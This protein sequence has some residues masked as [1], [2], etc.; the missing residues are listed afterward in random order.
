MKKNIFLFT[1][2]WL[3]LLPSLHAQKASARLNTRVGPETKGGRRDIPI[4]AGKDASNY[5]IVH[6]A[7]GTMTADRLGKSDLSLSGTGKIKRKRFNT[8]QTTFFASHIFGD[9]LYLFYVCTDRYDNKIVLLAREFDGDAMKS[10][11]EYVEVASVPYYNLRDVAF[12]QLFDIRISEDGKRMLIVSQLVVSNVKRLIKRTQGK[13]HFQMSV[14]DETFTQIW[15]D[16]PKLPFKKEKFAIDGFRV[17]NNGDVYAVMVEVKDREKFKM[18]RQDVS[19]DYKYHVLYFPQDGSEFV[20][21]TI[22]LDSGFVTE[23]QVATG[24]S[25]KIVVAGFYSKKSSF[26]MQGVFYQEYDPKSG[27]LISA[28]SEK[29]NAWFTKEEKKE[30]KKT[31]KKPNAVKRKTKKGGDDESEEEMDDPMVYNL[32]LSDL[33]VSEDGH[34]A[35]IAEQYYMI[36]VSHTTSNGKGGTTT[37]YT[38]YYYYND[39]LA[40][41]FNTT[42]DIA[43]KSRIP[44]RQ[45]SV[46][47]GGRFSSFVSCVVNNDL[48]LFFNQT[49]GKTQKDG[50]EEIPVFYPGKE[51][52]VLMVSIDQA[53]E[54]VTEVVPKLN[55]SK[56]MMEPGSSRVF[57]KKDVVLYLRKG[58]FYKIAG[59][60]FKK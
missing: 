33:L 17:E 36:V 50:K 56:F 11:G 9:K 51:T 23:M 55:N 10:S 35:L 4:L 1:L 2:C 12:S 8:R 38:Y 18:N 42:G 5:Y 43:W 26:N 22:A 13:P 58:A 14:Y 6:V 7:P 54:A 19:P 30:V 40:V 53:G 52:R 31:K 45:R 48:H 41:N 27:E 29:I 46:N 37:T 16:E 57:D 25:G 47:D 32:H 59:L 3:L 49:I 21:I 34:V 24:K 28:R 20:D 15:Q 44:K 60:T 39:I